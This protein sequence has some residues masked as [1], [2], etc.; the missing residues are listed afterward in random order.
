MK[1]H[2][3]LTTSNFEAYLEA[4]V[5]SLQ[6]KNWISA[7]DIALTLPGICSNVDPRTKSLGG[8]GKR[9]RTWYQL[10]VDDTT[11][12]IVRDPGFLPR[13]EPLYDAE[14]VYKLRCSM[15]HQG[16]PLTQYFENKFKSDCNDVSS[17]VI[18]TYAQDSGEIPSFVGTSTKGGFV[19]MDSNILDGPYEIEVNI[20]VK[21]LCQKLIKASRAYYD[22]NRQKFSDFDGLFNW[23]Y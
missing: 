16:E 7:L 4:A 19:A 13:I 6:N 15:L 3:D 22:N 14:L 21:E 23:D 9:Y 2:N 20:F 18:K 11:S 1:N 12:Q 10:N 17:I 8:D 5:Q